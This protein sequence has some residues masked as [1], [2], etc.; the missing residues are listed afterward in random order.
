MLEQMIISKY[1]TTTIGWNQGTTGLEDA[2]VHIYTDQ[3]VEIAGSPFDCTEHPTIP[4][5][6]QTEVTVLATGT[7]LMK[8]QVT[9]EEVPTQEEQQ[10]LVVESLSTVHPVLAR[11][12]DTETGI[13]M[14]GVEVLFLWHDGNGWVLK[15]SDTT[16][17]I[18]QVNVELAEGNYA[19][20]L[21]KGAQIF[22]RNNFSLEVD[23]L[24]E[25]TTLQLRTTAIEPPDVSYVP[26]TTFVNMGLKLVNAIGTPLR[27]R[28]I[29]IVGAEP[30]KYSFGENFIIAE[31]RIRH[32][33]DSN[34]LATVPMLPGA[35][36]TVSVEGTRVSRRFTVP[37]EAFNLYDFMDTG[38]VFDAIVRPFP[39][40][41]EA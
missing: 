7:Y 6:Y 36:V 28:G 24:D 23:E 11:V 26:P 38:D 37:D 29:V 9:V 32:E 13:T 40:A 39:E 35:V 4:G 31:D 20:C 14:S 16:D 5:V 3:D 15:A 27:Y 30:S 25:T 8:W 34:G 19:V 2:H 1:V 41:E 10:L 17:Q 12:E 21:R 18:G 22:S 33:T